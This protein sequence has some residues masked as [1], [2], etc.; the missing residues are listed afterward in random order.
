MPW[1]LYSWGKSKC[2]P[3][4]N[5]QIGPMRQ[6]GYFG[7]AINQMLVSGFEAHSSLIIGKKNIS[8]WSRRL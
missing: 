8:V 7:E 5:E 3:M 1:Q 2:C 4:N 6:R